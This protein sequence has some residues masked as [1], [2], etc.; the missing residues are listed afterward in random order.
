MTLDQLNPGTGLWRLQHHFVVV[1]FARTVRRQPGAILAGRRMGHANHV[2]ALSRVL[3][4]SGRTGQVPSVTQEPTGQR[5][6][7]RPCLDS[8]SDE[9]HVDSRLLDDF[10]A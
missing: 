10:R 7:Q 8:S 3:G 4:A 5:S 9:P 2:E 1:E 6:T